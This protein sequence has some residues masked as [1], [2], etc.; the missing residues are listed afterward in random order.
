MLTIGDLASNEKV[1]D[2]FVNALGETLAVDQ[3]RVLFIAPLDS[4][5]G[6]LAHVRIEAGDAREVTC[7][8]NH[9]ERQMLL[10]KGRL[11]PEALH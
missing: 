11:M 6:Y 2:F 5:S 9:S 4:G 10:E 3:F 8:L 1:N 7:I